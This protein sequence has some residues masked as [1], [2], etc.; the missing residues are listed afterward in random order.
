MQTRSQTY[1]RG[2]SLVLAIVM[3][4]TLFPVAAFAVYD[5]DVSIGEDVPEDIVSPEV[6]E[7]DAE[8]ADE[9]ARYPEAT[10][11]E[12]EDI[13]PTA[14]IVVPVTVWNTIDDTLTSANAG[15]EI[16]F[17]LQ[18]DIIVQTVTTVPAGVT[19][20]LF[21]EAGNTFAIYNN[22]PTRHF[23]VAGTLHLHNVRLTRDLAV[24]GITTI[25]GIDFAATGGGGVTVSGTLTMHAGSVI[26]NSVAGQGGGVWIGASGTLNIDGGIIENNRV[27]GGVGTWGGGVETTSGSTINMTDGYIRNNYGGANSH[28][29]GVSLHGNGTVFNMSGGS[30]EGNFVNHTGSSSAGAGAMR[31]AFGA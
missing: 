3:L 13:S 1:K 12:T 18:N 16:S 27:G 24:T 21:S 31:V 7:P 14:A 29:G 5:G 30:M 19:V 28:S 26:S 2:L 22:T 20:N 23:S 25:E 9:T 15:D 17:Y 11:P 4:I 8:A 6:A 10:Y